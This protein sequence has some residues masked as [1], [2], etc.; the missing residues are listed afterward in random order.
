MIKYTLF[1]LIASSLFLHA[2]SCILAKYHVYIASNLPT[3]SPPL[4]VHCSSK[5]DDLGY[6][7][8]APGAEYQFSFCE[9]PLATLFSCRFL[10]N[11]N[12]KGFHVYDAKWDH[13]RCIIGN[14]HGVCYY[15]V[16]PAGFFFTNKYPPKELDFLCGWDNNNKYF[17]C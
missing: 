2:T 14:R 1:L 9:N 12:D 8:L 13:N 17:A 15:A 6:H 7:T 3:N 16:K 5:D 4:Q 11:G 10:W